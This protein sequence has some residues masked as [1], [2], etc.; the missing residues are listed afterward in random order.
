MCVTRLVILQR[1]FGASF[2]KCPKLK[3]KRFLQ[4]YSVC[5][6]QRIIDW[7]KFVL[8]VNHKWVEN[9][10]PLTSLGWIFC[11]LSHD[12]C[13]SRCIYSLECSSRFL[14]SKTFVA[15]SDS[16]GQMCLENHH[17]QLWED[18]KSVKSLSFFTNDDDSENR[19]DNDPQANDPKKIANVF[20]FGLQKRLFSHFS[21]HQL[22]RCP[23]TFFIKSREEKFVLRVLTWFSH[24]MT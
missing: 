1:H 16:S 9:Q 8:T 24:T 19:F 18:L 11:G 23:I 10:H 15:S 21:M 20:I 7:P 12:L 14:T 22:S 6:N 2:V 17:R 4:R 3:R 5:D 13:L